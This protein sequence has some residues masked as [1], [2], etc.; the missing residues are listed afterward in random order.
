[1][2]EQNSASIIKKTLID[3]RLQVRS[4]LTTC[5]V[6]TRNSFYYMRHGLLVWLSQKISVTCLLSGDNY[7]FLYSII[8]ASLRCI[9]NNSK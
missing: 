2:C 8:M 4:H 5:D 1:M 3:L 7:I 6:C 9:S